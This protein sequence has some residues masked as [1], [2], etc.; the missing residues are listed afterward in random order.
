MN[1]GTGIAI[2]GIWI[3]CGLAWNNRACGVEKAYLFALVAI[4]GT[5][6][7]SGTAK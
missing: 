7:L 1:I 3:G 6:L 2:L 5:L 4:F